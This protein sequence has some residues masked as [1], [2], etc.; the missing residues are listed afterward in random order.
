METDRVYTLFKFHQCLNVCFEK[1]ND[2]KNSRSKQIFLRE[3]N[4][5]S[6]SMA[7]HTLKW[8]KVINLLAQKGTQRNKVYNGTEHIH[9]KS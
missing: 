4:K 5:F 9:K 1:L 7:T 3:G 2:T 8:N 6:K